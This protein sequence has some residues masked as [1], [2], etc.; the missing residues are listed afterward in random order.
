MLGS[1]IVDLH[2]KAG[3]PLPDSEWLKEYAFAD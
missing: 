3:A 1:M 2:K